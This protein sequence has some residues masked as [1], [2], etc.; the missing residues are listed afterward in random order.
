MAKNVPITFSC[1]IEVTMLRNIQW[2][3]F[4]S[5]GLVIDNQLIVVSERVADLYLE[6]AGIAFLAVFTHIGERNPN[7]LLTLDLIGLPD[8]FVEAIYA[9]MQGI[10]AIIFS[11]DVFHSV[12]SERAI[13]NQIG[14]AP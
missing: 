13:S 8:D 9:A 12:Q 5:C 3:R 7:S 10:W 14:L 4:V 2:C 6:I 11:Q 1:Q